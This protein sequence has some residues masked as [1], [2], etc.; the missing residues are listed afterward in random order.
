MTPHFPAVLDNTIIKSYKSCPYETYLKYFL[1][2]KPAVTSVHLIAGKAYADAL[3]VYRRNLYFQNC[4]KEESLFAALLTAIKSYGP[5]D[6]ADAKKTWLAVC[7]AVVYYADRYPKESEIYKPL[8]IEGRDSLEFSMAIPLPFFHPDTDE[9]IVYVGRADQIVKSEVDGTLF[10]EDDKTVSE[11][12]QTWQRKH[13]T[14]SQFLGYTYMAREYGFDVR[15]VLIR[16]TCFYVNRI[17]GDQSL[18]FYPE[19]LLNSWYSSLCHTVQLMINDYKNNKYA[20]AFNDACTAY[21]GCIF[22][23]HCLHRYPLTR[24]DFIRKKWDP[25]TRSEI[26][27]EDNYAQTSQT[28]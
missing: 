6:F 1:N 3:E 17:D 11:L 26:T 25:V 24:P 14:D 7:E 4:S 8:L 28:L 23:E 19:H 21:G 2:I 5:H 16:A 13:R 9:P 18:N 20:Q 27:L 10:L 22:Q 12:G 15:G